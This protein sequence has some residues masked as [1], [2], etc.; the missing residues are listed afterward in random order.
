MLLVGG[1][2]RRMG[3]DK[4]T[5]SIDG[6][7]LWERQFEL[8]KKLCPSA[9]WLSARILSPWIPSETEIVFDHL[10]SQGPLSGITAGLKVARTSHLLVLAV[11][12]PQMTASHLA[13]L[14]ALAEPAVGVIPCRDNYIE[15][16]CAIY[17]VEAAA[18]ADRTLQNGKASVQ[19]FGQRLLEQ[20]M[21]KVYR[22][23]QH[24]KSLYFNMNELSDIPQ[25]S[26]L[27][28]ADRG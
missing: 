16:L 13:K 18:L 19:N 28:S 27:S 22:L 7:P 4:A 20:E 11:D 21:A 1:F 5:I 23:S 2:S 15:P 9:L 17:P 25:T 26:N 6:K 3:V 14:W 8:L 24:E 10:P 12:L